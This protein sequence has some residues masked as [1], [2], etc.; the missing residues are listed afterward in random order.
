MVERGPAKASGLSAFYLPM[1]AAWMKGIQG[2]DGRV[3][4][5]QPVPQKHL[6][7]RAPAVGQAN[8]L[9]R[10][11]SVNAMVYTR[12][13]H[14]DY[15]HWDEFLGGKAAGRSGICLPHFR[16]MEYNHSFHDE[17][18]GVDGPLHV[19]DTGAKCQLTEDYVLA[20][21][22]LAFPITL[23]SMARA[24]LASAPCNTPHAADAGRMACSG[25]VPSVRIGATDAFRVM[26]DTLVTR[27]VLSRRAA[28]WRC[29]PAQWPRRDPHLRTRSVAGRWQLQHAEAA[30]AVRH[31]P[32]GP[33]R[34]LRHQDGARH[35]GGG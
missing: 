22:A 26:T 6:N 15:D 31:W 18:H 23:I 20:V 14:E 30:H 5:H 2:S 1:P 28:P 32:C 13:Q 8:I 10:G 29:R 34:K 25:H 11:T 24:R 4:M 9:G 17:W 7:G 12:G 19:S 33:S 27:I 16:G 21:Q 35:A 3:E